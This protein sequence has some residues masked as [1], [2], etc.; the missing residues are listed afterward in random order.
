MKKKPIYK[1]KTMGGLIE[2]SGEKGDV[3]R[4]L[5]YVRMLEDTSEVHESLFDAVRKDRVKIK[6]AIDKCVERFRK[7]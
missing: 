1:A 2:V 6:E 3:E 7:A 5:L 4:Y